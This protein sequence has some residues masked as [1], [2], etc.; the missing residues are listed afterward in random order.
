MAPNDHNIRSPH[1]PYTMAQTE[2]PQQYT[3]FVGGHEVIWSIKFTR[4]STMADGTGRSKTM[5][6]TR[7]G[8]SLNS[9]PSLVLLRRLSCLSIQICIKTPFYLPVR[10]WYSGSEHVINEAWVPRDC[11]DCLNARRQV[12]S[13]SQAITQ[14]INTDIWTLVRAQ[15]RR[16]T[17]RSATYL[18]TNIR[19]GCSAA[20]S[21]ST[22]WLGGLP[23]RVPLHVG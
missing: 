21:S 2:R 22:W 15:R 7:L 20:N 14:I 12:L 13:L 9:K 1:P 3:P 18:N 17:P 11:P 8:V 5:D 10:G 16:R 6:E 4:R 19:E 23:D